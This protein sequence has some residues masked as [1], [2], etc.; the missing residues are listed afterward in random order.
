MKTKWERISRLCDYSQLRPGLKHA[1][2]SS[3]YEIGEPLE[4]ALC[5]E[6]TS[7]RVNP[8]GMFN[9]DRK[10]LS[11]AVLITPHWLIQAIQPGVGKTE[12]LVVFNSYEKMQITDETVNTS[13]KHGIEEYG[14]DVVSQ[15]SRDQNYGSYFI[16]LE[17]GAAAR[18]FLVTLKLFIRAANLPLKKHTTQD[19]QEH[20]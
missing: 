16:G 4:V 19:K 18:Q 8:G 3:L 6:T 12:P 11:H 13:K 17:R 9:N 5:I 10:N 7:T 2:D 14:I 15:T 20:G 1:I